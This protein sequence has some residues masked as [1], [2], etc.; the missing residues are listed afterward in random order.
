MYVGLW[1]SGAPFDL[2]YEVWRPQEAQPLTALRYQVGPLNKT[3]TLGS[4]DRGWDLGEAG[5]DE[6]IEDGGPRGL[7]LSHYG[8]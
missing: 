8:M 6:R 2:F 7:H 3:N 4:E 5:S 1:F